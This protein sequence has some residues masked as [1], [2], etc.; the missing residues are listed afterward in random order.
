MALRVLQTVAAVA[1]LCRF[2]VT[3]TRAGDKTEGTPGQ[4]YVAAVYEHRIILNPEPHVPLSRTAALKHM[5]SNLDVYEEQAA[6]AA[7]QGAQIIVFPEDGLQGFNFSRLSIS[8]YLETIPDPQ[9][10]DWNPCTQTDRHTHTEVLQRLSCMARRHS[11]YLV[12]N[13]ADLQPC[14]LTSHPTCPPDGRWQ[15]N[16]DVVFRWDGSLAARYHKHNLYFENAFDAPPRLEVVTFDTPFAG[17]FGVFTCFDILFHDPTI[18]LLEQGIRQMVYPTAWM[19]QLPLLSAV[20]FQRA[21]SLGANS[22]LLA[23]NIR[24]DSLGMTGSGIFTPGTAIYHHARTGQPEEGRLLVLRIPV[25]DTAWLGTENRAKGQA[26][27]EGETWGET[28]GGEGEAGGE[29]ARGEGEAGGETARGEGE[30]GAETARG[31][32][33]AG[34]ETARGEGEAGGETARGEGEAGGEG[35]TEGEAVEAYT[36]S[37]KPLS[38]QR[39]GNSGFCLQESQHCQEDSVSTSPPPPFPFTSSMMYDTFSFL[40]LSGSE[41]QLTVCDGPFCCHLQYRRSPLGD[42]AELYALGAFSGTHTV[43][44]RY[45]VQVC[46]LVRCLGP[47]V[48]SC[49][50]EVEEAESR[51]DFLLEGK[52]GTRHV[53]PSLLGSGMVLEQPD[54]VKTTADGRVTMEHSGMT[55]GL[56]TAC[57]YGR[58]YDQD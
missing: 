1:V 48:S 14:P 33:E 37:P 53:Y 16:T 23:A 49:G 22:T 32:G 52:F 30:A 18:R 51:V 40:L 17:R 11:L 43:N 36:R 20:Q 10:E 34:G 27:G 44:G 3:L 24:A 21:F 41:G 46:A 35:E 25:L 38:G 8:G 15:F 4:S 45:N 56:V 50:Q 29:T 47:E 9:S 58:V 54:Q 39:E 7:Q 13:M 28:A 5:M 55:V 42:N 12:A 19:N 26:G 2:P 31:E 6:R 57:L